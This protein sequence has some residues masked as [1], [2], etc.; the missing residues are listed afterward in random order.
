MPTGRS[1]ECE[2]FILFYQHRENINSLIDWIP[3][4]TVSAIFQLCTGANNER[5]MDYTCK[6]RHVTCENLCSKLTSVYR[7]KKSV[8]NI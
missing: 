2:T 4:Y 1:H 3:F 6:S 5:R 8:V 7:A